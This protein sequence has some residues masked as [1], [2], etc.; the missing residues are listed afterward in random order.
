MSELTDHSGR[1]DA[2]SLVLTI[3]ADEA[4][5]GSSVLADDTRTNLPVAAPSKIKP[6]RRAPS[7]SMTT[8]EVEQTAR[9]PLS[10]PRFIFSR[11]EYA[12]IDGAAGDLRESLSTFLAVYFRYWEESRAE[13]QTLYDT[14][15]VFSNVLSRQGCRPQGVAKQ[16]TWAS[17]LPTISRLPALS[18]DDDMDDWVVDA[19][20][21]PA[22]DGPRVFC[23]V[24]GSFTE[25]PKKIQRAFDRTFI[26]RPADSR[27]LAYIRHGVR[28][29]ILR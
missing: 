26:L 28:W 2:D 14:T 25:F 9:R 27:S 17:I 3:V 18:H 20:M 16:H 6:G 19:W 8:V 12:F 5:R 29:V 15:A 22:T 10:P 11:P 4:S 23:V 1:F 13:L 21:H 24:H 7:E